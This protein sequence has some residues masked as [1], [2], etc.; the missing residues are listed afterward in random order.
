ED[1]PDLLA[2]ERAPYPERD[3]F[4]G[5]FVDDDQ[6]SNARTGDE[7]VTHEVGGPDFVWPLRT[8]NRGFQLAAFLLRHGAPPMS[9]TMLIVEAQEDTSTDPN[10]TLAHSAMNTTVSPCRLRPGYL[11]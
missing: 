1:L 9:E 6:E 10:A 11:D 7:L 4:S 3:D 8:S 2:A 5:E